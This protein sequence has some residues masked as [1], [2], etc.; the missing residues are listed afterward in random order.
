MSEGQ[1]ERQMR[2]AEC[3]HRCNALTIE[4][5]TA[6]ADQLRGQMIMADR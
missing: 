5:H 6:A 1:H 4:A 2:V 3:G